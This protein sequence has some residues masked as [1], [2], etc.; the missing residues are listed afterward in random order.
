MQK[1][2]ITGGTG[3]IGSE[4]AKAL[5]KKGFEVIILSRG[6]KTWT[7][8]QP[9]FAQWDID[10]GTM[11]TLALADVDFI[12]NLAGAGVMD[13]RW[14]NEYKDEIINSRTRSCALLVKVLTTIPNKVKAVISA[15]AI[16]W[17]PASENSSAPGFTEEALPAD[18]FLGETCRQWEQ[19]IGP[20]SGLY[21]RL[22][23]FRIGIVLGNGGAM[24]EFSRS[25]KF[26]VAAIM[27][28]GKQTV[29]WIHVDDLCQMILFALENN[30][31]SGIYNAVAP[32]PVTNQELIRTLASNRIRGFYAV[33]HIPSIV[34]KLLLGKRSL[35]ILKST[36]VSC[37]KILRAGFIF[38]HP[39]V[40]D[41]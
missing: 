10:R 27:G 29:S 31:I 13:K 23:I 9:G 26:R 3:F 39:R 37:T 25:F 24:K 33:I 20:I 28:N 18:N 5:M 35:E 17:Y 30:Q 32:G 19:S 36:Y 8:R 21:K 34:V 38:N 14:S 11:D 41:I 40:E 4:L 1:V 16:G 12:V 2:M 7:G 15:S 22:V 6:K